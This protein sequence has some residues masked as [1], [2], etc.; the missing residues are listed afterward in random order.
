MMTVLP[1]IEEA[2]ILIAVHSLIVVVVGAVVASRFAFMLI[3][4]HAALFS[5]NSES[6]AVKSA[7]NHL[8]FHVGQIAVPSQLC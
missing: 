7:T 6:S 5:D 8:D 1:P 4:M 3:S 2:A